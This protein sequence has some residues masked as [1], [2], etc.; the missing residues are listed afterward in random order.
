MEAVLFREWFHL[1]S[2]KEQYVPD[3]LIPIALPYQGTLPDRDNR[4]PRQTAQG[5]WLDIWVPSD[6]VPGDYAF[7]AILRTSRNTSSLTVRVKVLNSLAPAED[8]ITID[9]NS[10]G[11]SWFAAQYPALVR[12]IGP[13]FFESPDFFALIHAYYRMFYEHRGTFH[14]LGYGHAG[15]VGPEF[16]PALDGWGKN[17]HVTSWDEY[18]RH[19]GPLLDGAAFAKTH[20]GPKPIL[21]VYLPINPEWPATFESW[22]EPGYQAEFVHV[23]TEMEHHFREKGWTHTNFEIFFN[24]K[25]R[26]RGFDWD[27]D[28]ARFTKDYA[29]FREYARLLKLAVPADSPVKFVFRAD[30]SWTMERQ[31][32]DLAGVVNFWVCGGGMFD[33]FPYAPG[34]LKKRGDTVW[35]YGGTPS[36]T[37]PSSRITLDLLRAWMQGVQGFVRWETTAPGPDPWFHFGGGRETLVYP[38][39]RFGIPGPIPSI[40]LKIERNAIQD[41]DLLDACARR[42]D[43]NRILREVARIF[44][45]TKPEDWWSPRPALAD[46]DP[47]E[48][49]NA[50][51]DDATQTGPQF[52]KLLDSAAWQR[53]RAYA[54]QLSQETP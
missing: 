30:V 37:E 36:I 45:Q 51:I 3:A 40:R 26:Y 17:K 4:I 11:T 50:D 27:G 39:D 21:F 25:K 35:T 7:T 8:A 13:R 14:Q 49:S 54:Y 47:V 15:K 22:G 23:V 52:S 53:L 32:R 48:W 6:T 12:R 9:H 34:M 31:W 42:G 29:Y 38:G 10:Y 1:V 28:E 5:F 44:N 41:I 46:T 20:R 2:E 19:Y 24:Q 16:A 18:D 43:A 33:W